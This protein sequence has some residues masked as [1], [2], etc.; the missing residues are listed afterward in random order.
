MSSGTAPIAHET[1]WRGHPPL[2]LTGARTLWE[3]VERRAATDPDGVYLALFGATLTCGEL[4]RT[5]LRYAGAL[6]AL[7]LGRDDKV[8]LVLP[9][10]REFGE[11][12]APADVEAIVDAL[13]GIRYSAAIG[14]DSGRTG[15]QRLH[16][17]AEV[18]GEPREPPALQR[19][20]R[21]VVAALRRAR[22]LRPARIHLVGP[23]TI[24]KTSSG[25]IQRVALGQALAADRLAGRVLYR[26]GAADG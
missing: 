8:V 21:D 13:P 12:V 6:Q 22:G 19:L 14:L 26:T 25:K 5:S 16:V 20:A 23:Q 11:N 3:L 2:D 17:V 18:R 1:R 7:G 9:T 10:C 4:R 24:P 15:T